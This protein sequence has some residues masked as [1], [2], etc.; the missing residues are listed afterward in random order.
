[1][2]RNRHLLPTPDGVIVVSHDIQALG[3]LGVVHM[4]IQAAAGEIVHDHSLGIHLMDQVGLEVRPQ[5]LH[6]L[7]QGPAAGQGCEW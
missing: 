7:G 4:L 1:M 5:I 2:G 6:G 3:H